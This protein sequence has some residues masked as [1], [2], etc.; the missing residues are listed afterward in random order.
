MN[1]KTV[2]AKVFIALILFS[3][4]IGVQLVNL[5]AANFLPPPP[6]LPSIYIRSDGTVDPPAAIQRIGEVYTFTGNITDRTLEIQRDN[7]VVDGAGYTLQGNTSGNGIKLTNRT[8]VTIKNL[9]LKQFRTC[10]NIHSSSNIIIIG[11]TITDNGNAIAFDSSVNNRIKGNKI[12]GNH[13][14]ILLYNASSHNSIIGNSIENNGNGIW[15]EFNPSP[16]SDNNIIGNNVSENTNFG[17]LLRSS[18]N[19]LVEGNRVENNE[20]G[21]FLSG[22]ACQHN[23][24]V[25]NNIANNNNGIYIGGDPKH[26]NITK[27]NIANNGR[28]IYV[29]HSSNNTLYQNNFIDNTIQIY[30]TI[31]EFPESNAPSANIWSYGAT[32]NYWSNYNGTDSDGDGIGDIPYIIDANNQD[33]YPLME[34]AHIPEF[35]ELTPMLLV[36]AVLTVAVAIYKQRLIKLRNKK[37]MSCKQ[38]LLEKK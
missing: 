28:G 22:S 19:D 31:D 33:P 34:T 24:I 32:G 25:D 4:L 21:I 29:S 26:N 36:L 27:N 13:V 37:R 5:A 16:S 15:S 20:D 17:I 3:A 38:E 23:T 1:T 30:G 8:G 12:A 11:N 10:I 35:P 7:I 6:S 9:E 18:S 14:A 2:L